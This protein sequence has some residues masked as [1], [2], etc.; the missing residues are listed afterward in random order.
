[1][2]RSIA[3]LGGGL[4]GLVTAFYLQKFHSADQALDLQLFEAGSRVGGVIGTRQVDVP[5]VGTFTL[6]MGADMFALDPPHAMQLVKDLSL[7]DQLLTPD[8][9]RAGALV[10]HRGKLQPIPDGFVLMRA[11]KPW[12][13]LTTP[14]LSPAA[15][16]RFLAERF[17][18]PLASDLPDQDVSVGQFVRHRL[19]EEMLQR[20]VGPLV[21]GI[22]TADVEKLSMNATMAPIV[23][24]VQQH[25]SLAKAT[26]SRKKG[27]NDK[28][29]RSSAGARYS[30]FRGFRNGM[31]QLID[32]LSEQIGE[33]AIDLNT[34]V[35]SIQWDVARNKW[36]VST[37][38]Q[39]EQAFD[40]VVVATPSAVAAKLLRGVK[41]G[42]LI[43]PAVDAADELAAIEASSA[44]IVVLAVRKDQV[45]RL[46]RKFG[47]VVPLIEGRKVLA[48]SFASHKYAVRAPEDHVIIRVFIGGSMQP[49][50]LENS[51][52]GLIELAKQELADLIGLKGQETISQVVRWNDAMP[53]YHVG[54]LTRV[55]RIRSAVDQ[56]PNL[57]M[58][59]NAM[60]GVGIAPLSG[61]A[62]Q[63][64][65][66]M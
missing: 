8:A 49:E 61:I 63:T 34:P 52:A 12:Q 35:E 66:E 36:L 59:N 3:V 15:K 60:G 48:V 29:E 19:G 24:M 23:K 14:I 40:S 1:M 62:K 6:D 39:S 43:K 30:K 37:A 51:D 26:L 25:G 45:E 18:K 22:Y 64:A 42:K 20:L 16:L 4:S 10:V 13:L 57:W 2:P 44:A 11:T 55:E 54:H 27:D 56:L 7:E 53:Q 47:F 28:A 5:D 33:Q 9:D 31:Q 65:E 58:V 41:A 17:I 50:L 21:A 46:P 32:A 38:K